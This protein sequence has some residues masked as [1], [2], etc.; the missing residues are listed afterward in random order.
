MTLAFPNQSRSY[1]AGRQAVHFLGYDGMFKVPF[2]VE[3]NALKPLDGGGNAEARY[4]AAFDAARKSIENAARKAY[5]NKRSQL[6]VL[7]AADL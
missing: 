3:T 6:Y 2:F 4:L 5:S 1:D 7:T